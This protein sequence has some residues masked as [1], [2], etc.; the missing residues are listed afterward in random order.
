M[1]AAIACVDDGGDAEATIG[2]T[3]P[4]AAAPVLAGTASTRGWDAPDKG[5]TRSTAMARW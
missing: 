2:T 1:S 5:K 4:V 3:E